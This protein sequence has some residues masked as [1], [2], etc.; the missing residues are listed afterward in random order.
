M[1]EV[2]YMF[3]KPVEDKSSQKIRG[4]GTV[5]LPKNIRES[6]NLKVG[7]D[8]KLLVNRESQEVLIRK[9][10]KAEGDGNDE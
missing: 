1:L 4:V 3:E 2:M 9:A 5:Y 6:I 8:V 7:E 10:K